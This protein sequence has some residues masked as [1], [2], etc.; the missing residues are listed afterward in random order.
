MAE[1]QFV[2][3]VGLV[4]DETREETSHEGPLVQS[5]SSSELLSVYRGFEPEVQAL[6]EVR[7]TIFS[8]K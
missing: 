7:A 6:L 3:V 2:N 1:G 5:V 4:H 8:D